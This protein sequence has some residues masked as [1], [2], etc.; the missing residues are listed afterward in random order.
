[1]GRGLVVLVTGTSI[2]CPQ[3]F[4]RDIWTDKPAVGYS[5]VAYAC[6]AC[7]DAWVGDAWVDHHHEPRTRDGSV[8]HLS[9]MSR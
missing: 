9:R 5:R 7:G 3:C 2:I 8:G 4:E 6:G 1:M